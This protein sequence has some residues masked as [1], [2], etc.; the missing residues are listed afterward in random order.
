MVTLNS[1]D[2]FYLTMAVNNYCPSPFRKSWP[3]SSIMQQYIIKQK[4]RIHGSSLFLLR[5]KNL[6]RQSYLR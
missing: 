1:R 3:F 2:A 5:Q 4:F 6:A